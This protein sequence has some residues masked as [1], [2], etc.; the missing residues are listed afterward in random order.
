[1]NRL[2][3]IL[4]FLLAIV[5][6][7]AFLFSNVIAQQAQSGP[8]IKAGYHYI[9]YSFLGIILI[10][11]LFIIWD[12]SRRPDLTQTNMLPIGIEAI[13]VI[14]I[15]ASIVILALTNTITSEGAV[16][17]LGSIVGYVLGKKTSSKNNGDTEKDG[18]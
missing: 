5:S 9:A 17:V 4:F 10:G 6:L 11:C 12:M 1:M 13:T 14:L 8:I 18:A 16:G 15:V 3:Y 7:D 2:F